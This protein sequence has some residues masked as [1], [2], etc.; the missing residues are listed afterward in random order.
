[1]ATTS[2]SHKVFSGTIW[3]S[4][5]RIGTMV[6]QFIVNL[7]LARLLMPDDFGYIGMLAIFISVSQ[8]LVDGGFGSALIQKKEPTQADYSTIFYWNLLFSIVLYCILFLIAPY[9]S[10][11][12]KLPLLSK[13]LRILGLILI[14]NALII[15]QKIVC[16]NSLNFER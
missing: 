10:H 6:L 8:T 3:A 16:V 14:I 1:M 13:L 15:V 4:I 12:F 2:L 9:I 11:F 5:D 7:I